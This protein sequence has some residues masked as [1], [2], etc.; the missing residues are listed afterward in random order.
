[1]LSPTN[2]FSLFCLIVG[3]FLLKVCLHSI[4]LWLN[5]K[6]M[7]CNASTLEYTCRNQHLEFL[8]CLIPILKLF[9]EITNILLQGIH[10][11]I[12]L[13]CMDSQYT[14]TAYDKFFV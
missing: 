14:N 3:I 12:Q 2:D 13:Q 1:M 6:S 5:K 9:F 4:T 7:Y 10:T 11:L 8:Q